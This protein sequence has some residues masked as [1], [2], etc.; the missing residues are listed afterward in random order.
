MEKRRL[1]KTDL[2]VT[3]LGFGGARIGFEDVDPDRLQ[4]TLN[5]A[6]DL[7]INFLDTAACYEDGEELVGRY[8]SERRDE[9]VLAS[10]CGHVTGDARGKAWSPRVI[11]ESV[12]R[13]LTRLRTDHLDLLQLHSCSADVLRAG[14]A[15]EAVRK[16]Q[17]SGKTRYIGYSGDGED[18]LEAIRMGVFDTLQTSFNLV[19]QHA[20]GEVLPAA[21]RAGLGVIAKRPIANGALGKAAAPYDYAETYWK[22]SR[23]LQIPEGAPQN[24]VELSIRFTF[25]HDVIDTAIVGTTNP[26]HVR[27]NIDMVALSPLPS[28]I[29]DSLYEQFQRLGQD[30]DPQI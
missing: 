14:E 17:Q 29:L 2:K 8:V 27:E 24:P 12:D 28:P 25:S 18:A 30:W 7:G 1:G 23:Q 16:A 3:R 22:R 5:T 19:D 21:Q 13:S 11:S 6:L 10:K 9:Y 20:L 15:V 4:A 26:V